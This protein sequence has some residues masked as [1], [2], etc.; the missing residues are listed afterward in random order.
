M[1]MY[2]LCIYYVYTTE[3]YFPGTEARFTTTHHCTDNDNSQLILLLVKSFLVHH[4][5]EGDCKTVC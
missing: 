1:I 4:L 2:N 5:E 3:K